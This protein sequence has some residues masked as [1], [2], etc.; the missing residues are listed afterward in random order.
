MRESLSLRIS[1]EWA[2]VIQGLSFRAVMLALSQAAVLWTIIVLDWQQNWSI[3]LPGFDT[4]GAPFTH[5]LPTV[6]HVEV[7]ALASVSAYA[8]A[9]WPN[10]DR[11]RHGLRRSF[12]L[13]LLGLLLL[14]ALSI[15]W[16][17]HRGLAAVQVAHMAIWVSFTLMIICG[18]WSP[19]RL[20]AF[21]LGG[22]IIHCAVGY[23]Q[24]ALQHFV[25]LGPRFGE[26]PVRPYDPWVSV[27]FAGPIHILRVYG[28]SGHPNV[29]GGH[30]AVG[31]LWTYGLTIVWPR[32]WRALI[33]IA[34]IMA[35]GLLL[36]T[37]SRSAWIA[38]LTGGLVA[39]LWLTRGR[40]LNRRTLVPIL[41]LAALGLVFIVVFVLTFRP[42]LIGRFQA[43]TEP[44]ETLS[45]TERE[46][47]IRVST[48]LIAAYPLLGVGAANFSVASH[49]LGEE[50]SWAHNVPLLIGSELGLPGLALFL[51][52]VG[53]LARLGWQR[54]RSRSISLW[55]ALTGGG[56]VA[57]LTVM[58]FDHYPWTAPQ[59]TLLWALLTGLWLAGDERG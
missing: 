4:V 21:F 43:S 8:L 46:A 20:A 22:L 39:G 57:V 6:R 34:W 56:L 10:R 25:G 53:T 35:W 14:S 27:V 18:D 42:F 41:Q 45:I 2:R 52:M 44:Y 50:L 40:W 59:G 7:A 24:M 23:L 5:M 17:A 15:V 36:L 30:L 48:Q 1:I 31:L 33:M 49:A 54:W 37:F 38:T 32:V 12:T 11:L 29:L 13:A 19:P 58:L 9:G 16:A 51:V 3:D 28:L 26:L 55:Q 47:M